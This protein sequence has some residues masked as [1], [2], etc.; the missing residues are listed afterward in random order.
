MFK[1][2]CIKNTFIIESLK[3]QNHPTDLELFNSVPKLQVAENKDNTIVPEEHTEVEKENSSYSTNNKS[4]K[5][6]ENH[7]EKKNIIQK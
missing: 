2:N 3:N 6:N 1:D 4:V 5:M 7:V